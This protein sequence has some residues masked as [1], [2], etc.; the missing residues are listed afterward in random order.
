MFTLIE[1]T[2]AVFGDDREVKSL[3]FLVEGNNVYFFYGATLSLRDHV[4]TNNV[5]AAIQSFLREYTDDPSQVL[6]YTPLQGRSRRAR[7]R[8]INNNDHQ[9]CTPEAKAALAETM[10]FIQ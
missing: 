4:R 3:H 1:A 2:V 9:F 6:E 10:V 8:D 7:M 5:G